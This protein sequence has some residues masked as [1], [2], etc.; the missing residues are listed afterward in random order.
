MKQL[1]LSVLSQLHC[2]RY[3][4]SVSTIMTQL[5]LCVIYC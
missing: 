1:G 2:P 4:I 3:N 5:G